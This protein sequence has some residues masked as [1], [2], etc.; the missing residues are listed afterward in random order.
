MSTFDTESLTN[1]TQLSYEGVAPHP[2]DWNTPYV[3][4]GEDGGQKL[5]VTPED[6]LAAPQFKA[7]KVVVTDAASFIRYLEKHGD[8]ENTEI[9]VREKTVMAH[10]DAGTRTNPGRGVHTCQLTLLIDDDW[11]AWTQ[12]DGKLMSQEQFAEF[13]ED[14][15]GA[16]ISPDAATMIE[17]ATSMQVNRSVAFEQAQR[18]QDGN[19]RFAYR[20]DTTASAGKA[21]DLEIPA[22]IDLALPPFRGSQRVKVTARL[23]WRLRGQQLSIGVKLDRP[24]EIQKAAFRALVD[25]VIKWNIPTEGQAKHLLVFTA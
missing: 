10:I 13:L 14:N 19:V 24:A 4:R 25:E 15:A 11:A 8:A 1:L 3:I 21:G 23:R 6:E 18:L 22:V 20:E 7:E 16:V 17:I 12:A 2:L 9:H 5:V